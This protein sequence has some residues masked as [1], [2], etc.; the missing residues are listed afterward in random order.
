MPNT[1]ALS[2]GPGRPSPGLAAGSNAKRSTTAATPRPG[3]TVGGVVSAVVVVAMGFVVDVVDDE[4][5]TVGV[6]CE[7]A[8]GPLSCD[9]SRPSTRGRAT[10]VPPTRSETSAM[11]VAM[12]RRRR[13]RS[14][15]IAASNSCTA[16]DERFGS[17][18]DS[19]SSGST[20]SGSGRRAAPYRDAPIAIDSLGYGSRLIGREVASPTI[21][22]TRG[23][24][25]VPPRSRTRATCSILMPAESTARS[26]ERTVSL[27]CGRMSDSNSV[28][29]RRTSVSSSCSATGISDSMSLER[30]SFARRH[31]SRRR[32]CLGRVWGS[33]RSAFETEP[34][35]D[36]ST[37]VK[38]I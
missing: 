1:P 7:L 32:T 16:A 5:G 29:L 25:D 4:A 30:D 31:S 15:G 2:A 26:S 23:M 22:A 17:A 21:S 20:A 14:R 34:P 13:R 18:G 8:S 3:T 35:S 36:A 28:R 6:V 9:E 38:I 19:S 33:R 37:W 24:R 12:R 11:F 27:T 10:A